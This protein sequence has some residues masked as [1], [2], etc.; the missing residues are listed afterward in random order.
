MHP[1]AECLSSAY[2]LVRSASVFSSVV[3]W[4]GDSLLE[5]FLLVQDVNEEFFLPP[6]PLSSLSLPHPLFLSSQ[7]SIELN[8]RFTVVLAGNAC[9][10]H[11]Q[12][13]GLVLSVGWEQVTF[14]W[15]DSVCSMRPEPGLTPRL[16]PPPGRA[17][18]ST[19]SDAQ[20]AGLG[21]PRGDFIPRS[22]TG[23]PQTSSAA[24]HVGGWTLAQS[25][26]RGLEFRVGG[27]GSP[28]PTGH[29]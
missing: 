25:R 13:P 12:T 27:G 29:V 10:P 2:G 20:E 24:G 22:P 23:T 8:C 17:P 9:L 1:R 19:S 4:D 5:K 26:P 28:C 18:T 3:F 14:G 7:L 6:S 11:K 16:R 15:V 21:A